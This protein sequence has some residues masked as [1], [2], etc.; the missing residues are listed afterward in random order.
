MNT[1]NKVARATLFLKEREKMKI[2]V[3]GDVVS[4]IGRNTLYKYLEKNKS[5]FDL[6]IVNGENA[7]AGFGITPKIADEFFK[8]G[9]DVITLGNHTFDR[10]E[11]YEYLN[12]K[13]NIIRP[14]NFHPNAPGKG[15]TIL[16]IKGIRVCVMNMQGKTFMNYNACP[17][18]SI[19]SLLT[20]LSGRADIYI[21]DFHAE[22]TSEKQ[23]MGYTVDGKV[24][25]V[26]GTHTHV[27]TSDSKILEKGTAY[28]TDVGMTGPHGGVL[29]MD[30]TNI[31][32]KFKD[33]LPT[34]FVPATQDPRINGII[35]DI[36]V[37]NKIAKSIDRIDLAYEEI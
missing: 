13:E 27:Q 16:N 25:L 9:V 26:F 11:I 29:G 2:L 35:V 36:D 24:Q 7:A 4:E 6:I 32:K 15:Y 31:L 12:T 30:K 5:N 17:F 3:V 8:R 1:Q 22:A 10:K 18:L 21:L 37:I 23:G 28:I 33:N 34:K 19:E 14:Y 20:K